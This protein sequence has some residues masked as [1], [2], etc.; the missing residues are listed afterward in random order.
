MS[1]VD[2]DG[3]EHEVVL[4]L[5]AR[6]IVHDGQEIKA[7]DPITDGPFDPKELMEIKGI[8]EIQLYLVE[9]SSGCTAIRACRST[10]ST[11]S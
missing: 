2:D 9:E 3:D 11:S 6:P 5:G 8:R 10:T 1:V 4:P 7:G